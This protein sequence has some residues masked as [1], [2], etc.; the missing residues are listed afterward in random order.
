M[1]L[2]VDSQ[3]LLWHARDDPRLK[4]AP[5]AAI[6]SDDAQVLV[7]TASLW[8]IAIKS[9]LGKLDAPED[10]PE[11]V[12]QLGFEPL[13]VSAEHAWAVRGLPP[14]HGD[15]FDRLLAAQARV[16]RLPVVTADPSFERY[17]VEVIWE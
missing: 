3:V 12:E 8:E 9:A 5:T 14:N 10:L 13:P 11:R 4:P 15:P 7:S 2:L 17:G 1:R 6:E 16:E